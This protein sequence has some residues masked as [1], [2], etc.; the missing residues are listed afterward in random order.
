M[1]PPGRVQRVARVAR[2]RGS[3]VATTVTLLAH[4]SFVVSDALKAD[5]E[6][7]DGADGSR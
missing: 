4:D 6:K 3:P 5:F 1:T 7:D 2:R